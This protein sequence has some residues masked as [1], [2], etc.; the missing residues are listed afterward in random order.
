[1]SDGVDIYVTLEA[2]ALCQLGGISTI[3]DRDV[4]PLFYYLK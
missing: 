3:G 2:V 4:V 1:M